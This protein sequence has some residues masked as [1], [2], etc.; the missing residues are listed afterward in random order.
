MPIDPETGGPS[1]ALKAIQRT[2][3]NLVLA[4]I[5]LYGLVLTMLI[6]L[7]IFAFVIF[8]QSKDSHD[9]LCTFRANI[10]G[11]V[12]STQEFLKQHPEGL[13]K[14]GLPATTLQQT[15]ARQTATLA[16]LNSL[17]C[18]DQIDVTTTTVPTNT[19]G[20]K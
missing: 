13:P 17:N 4:T 14:L 15:L 11:Q 18:S 10:A 7:A 20:N 8:G 16:S 6:G 5:I 3:G 1:E 19:E 9:A 2:L 12:V